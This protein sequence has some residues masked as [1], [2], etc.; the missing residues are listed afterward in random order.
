[1]HYD[2][3]CSIIFTELPLLARPAAVAGAGFGAVEF[4]WPFGSSTPAD[5]EIGAFTAAIQDAGMRLVSLNFAAGDLAAGDRGL[6]SVPGRTQE[7]RDSVD[8]AVG[9]GGQLGC[10]SF[11]AP[12]G[13]RVDGVDPAAQ[14]E[15]ALENLVYA[16]RAAAAIDGQV[17]IEPLSGAARYPLLTTAD[18]LAVVNR[19]NAASGLANCAFL[20]DLYHLSVNGDALDTVIARHAVSI[21]H[22]QI[23]DVPGRG[24]PGSGRLSIEPRLAGLTAAGYD[25]WVGLEYIPTGASADS[26]AWLPLGQR[27]TAADAPVRDG[28]RA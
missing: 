7:F 19:V 3:N 18:A 11:N 21:G 22:V 9:I 20:A 25:G 8:V 5:G 1:M 10:R 27:S 4:W 17:L 12:Y 2:V 16:T 24:E 14:D 6:V 15:L 26:F 23:A 28:G 13:N